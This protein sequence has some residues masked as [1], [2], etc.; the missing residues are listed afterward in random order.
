[1][2]VIPD[3]VVELTKEVV[4]ST[5]SSIFGTS[6]SPSAL[7]SAPYIV[8]S[9]DSS[10]CDTKNIV[11]IVALSVWATFI[12]G[13]TIAACCGRDGPKG[14]RIRFVLWYGI[15]APLALSYELLK[16]CAS[17]QC[18]KC[19]ESTATT[20]GKLGAGLIE[21]GGVALRSEYKRMPKT[22]YDYGQELRNQVT[23]DDIGRQ[24]DRENRR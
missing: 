23:R 15:L 2:P 8:C 18:E 20:A 5:V 4:N 7:R 14:E 16:C 13:T 17:K 3:K 19:C 9:E 11:T 24:I 22:N 6:A 1:M 10:N 12:L 21:I